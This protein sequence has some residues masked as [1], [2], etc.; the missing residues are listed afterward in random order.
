MEQGIYYEKEKKKNLNCRY[1]VYK[2]IR[3]QSRSLWSSDVCHIKMKN[4]CGRCYSNWGHVPPFRN[5]N[6]VFSLASFS[7]LQLATKVRFSKLP[8]RNV[9]VDLRP[10]DAYAFY[11]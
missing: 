10:Q 9:N 8:L 4:P 3:S 11:S 7:G 5:S 6:C 1:A 2:Q